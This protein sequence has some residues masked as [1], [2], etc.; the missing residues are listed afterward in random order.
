MNKGKIQDKK[1]ITPPSKNFFLDAENLELDRENQEFNNALSLV[2]ETNQ[3]IFLTG[4]AGTGKT[5]FLKYITEK[6]I[7]NFIILAPTGV[8]AINSGGTTINSFFQIDFSVYV[9][10]DKRLSTEKE[11]DGSRPLFKNFKY[12]KSKKEIIKNLDILIIDE[13]SM[14]RC[15]I[16][17]VIDKILKAYRN[18]AKPFGGIQ[19]MLIGDVFQLPPILV[20]EKKNILNQFYNSGF[21]FESR[22][23]QNTKLI[24][25]ELKK[26]Y[27]QTDNEFI[28]MLN[29]IRIGQTTQND[30]NKLNSRYN[31]NF[32]EDEYIN[33]CTHNAIVEEINLNKLDN[34]PEKSFFYKSKISGS[35]PEN[36]FS[37]E[38]TLELKVGAQIMF[39]KNNTSKG[40]YNGKI[41]LISKLE[42]N[43][44]WVILKDTEVELELEEWN[45]IRYTYNK[46]R[47]TVEQEI[48]GTFNQFPIRLAWAITVHK[49]QGKT[50]KKVYA[51]LGDSFAPGQVYV[52][53]SRCTSFN[54]LFLKTK[55]N[56]DVIK[57]DRSALAFSKQE[58]T[59]NK[60]SEA[61]ICNINT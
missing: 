31:P 25:I 29:R 42:D 23:I 19:V 40:F 8:A 57:V 32:K 59:R 54:Q 61:D 27:R 9:P 60:H 35:F 22:I 7:K 33:L 11:K 16:I 46:E 1:P 2:N 20:G 15:D 44:V 43:R 28:E 18:N 58:N 36:N 39:I 34:L 53:L 30:I 55:I 37:T 4:K 41:A 12:K 14:V 50:F 48:I 5:T 3:N 38:K 17:D 21:F 56:S 26:I 24:H 6:T 47:K 52:A 51:D 49:S 10:N 13:I 45:N